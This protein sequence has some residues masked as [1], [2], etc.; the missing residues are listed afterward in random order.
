M[1]Q[2]I[3]TKLNLETRTRDL[4]QQGKSEREIAKILSDETMQPISKTAVHRLLVK[5][6]EP[7]RATIEP[8]PTQQP[9]AQSEPPTIDT[10]SHPASTSSQKAQK[11]IQ[12][13]SKQPDEFDYDRR[14]RPLTFWQ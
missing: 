8:V 14:R 1:N 10:S 6:I 12:F 3:I 5:P 13:T 9:I 4:K 11:I 7:P 2:N